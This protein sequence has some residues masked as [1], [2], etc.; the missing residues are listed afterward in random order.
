MKT[1]A[2]RLEDDVHAQLAMVAQLDGTTVTEEIRQAIEAHLTRKRESGELSERA[3]AVLAEIEQEAAAK[4]DAIQ[5]LFHQ[6]TTPP[7]SKGRRGT[8]SSGS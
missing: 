4:R 3:N 6:A 1:L 7:P 2:I 8:G 5:A